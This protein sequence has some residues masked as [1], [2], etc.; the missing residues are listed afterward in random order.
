M[1]LRRNTTKLRKTCLYWA[2]FGVLGW[3]AA[4]HAA[5]NP[6]HFYHNR[7]FLYQVVSA[8]MV[9]ISLVAWLILL[10][11]FLMEVNEDGLTL[12]L[13]GVTT[14]LPWQSVESLTVT[15]VGDSWTKP[16]LEIRLA[17]GVKL[18]G[19]LASKRDG[20]RVYTLLGLNDF[21]VV[22]EEVIACLQRYGG[23]RVDAQQ[24][25]Q[26]RAAVRCVGRYM[27]GDAVQADPYL[28]AYMAEQRR[29]EE[30]KTAARR[31][32]RDRRG[33]AERGD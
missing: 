15:K 9:T 5:A 13:R 1:Q 10:W 7:A 26:Y 28:T 27:R 3:W 30:E 14:R 32:C 12:R 8:V 2:I 6:D 33:W 4:W 21:T 16:N 23:G 25:L 18:G 19:R 29:I 20:P 24:Y 22:T 17:P 11:P 31:E